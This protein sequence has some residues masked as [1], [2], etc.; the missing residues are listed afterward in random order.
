MTFGFEEGEGAV[1]AGL[2][3]ERLSCSGGGAR[4]WGRDV[5]GC[6]WILFEIGEF[7]VPELFN[8][9]Y[10]GRTVDQVFGGAFNF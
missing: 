1:G 9:S 8:V 3:L 5:A 2:V 4:R 6:F 7:S 10:D